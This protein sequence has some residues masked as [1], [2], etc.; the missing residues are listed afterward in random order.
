MPYF[1]T[2]DGCRLYYET[3]GVASSKPVV[4]FLNGTMQSTLHWKPHAHALKEHFRVLRYD[5]RAQGQSDLGRGE[6]SLEAHAGDLS[7]LLNHLGVE[8]AHLVG[9]SHGARVALAYAANF[10]EGIARLVLCSISAEPT[11][12]AELMLRSWLQILKRSGLETMVWVSLPFVFGEVFL[13]Q[14]ERILASMVKAI[15]ARN[16]EDALIAQLE[17]M[18]AY[19]PL[20][21]MLRNVHSP[22]LVISASDDPLVTEEGASQLAGLCH[23]RHKHIK[24]IGHSIPSEAP[25]LFNKM[26]LEFLWSDASLH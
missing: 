20:S 22:C 1:I 17:A 10:P 6:L 14:K 25:E 24:G 9:V 15:V 2:Q 8:R 7:A 16:T 23:G 11:C 21:Q 12:R 26:I 3:Q 19:P 13:K 5:A 4:V 18:T